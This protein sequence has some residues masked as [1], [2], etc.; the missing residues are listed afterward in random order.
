MAETRI[1]AGQW[2]GRQVLTARGR[3][4]RPTTSLVRQAL[5]DILG[6]RVGGAAMV[7]LYAGA[8]TVGFEAL[9]RGAES[10]LFVERERANAALIT[11][12]AERLGC[13]DRC[14]V[15]VAP[16]LS[17]LRREPDELAA[18]GL[19]FLDAPY[20]DDE[21]ATALGLLGASPPALV[22]CEHHRAREL[23]EAVGRLRRVREATYGATRL[24]FWQ[25]DV[26]G[27]DGNP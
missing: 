8:G 26:D 13:A 3:E 24:S 16:V 9:S 1:T 18:A 21:V 2:R 6:D 22:V 19:C 20:R 23:P 12:T 4:L 14:R 17:W 5:F 27:G 11:A 25:R 15:A 10:A 7:D